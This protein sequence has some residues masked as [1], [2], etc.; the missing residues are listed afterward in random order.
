MYF[1]IH[2]TTFIDFDTFIY[3][4]IFYIFQLSEDQ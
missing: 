1:R 2:K 3:T 4:Y